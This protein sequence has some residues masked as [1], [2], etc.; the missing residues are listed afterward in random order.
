M[1]QLKF[2]IENGEETKASIPISDEQAKK[3]IELMTQ[4][5]LAH[6]QQTAGEKDERT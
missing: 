3:L 6:L 1:Q 5:I 4:A 2:T